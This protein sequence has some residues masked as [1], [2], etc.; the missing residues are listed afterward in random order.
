MRSLEPQR[1]RAVRLSL[2]LAS[3]A[4]AIIVAMI[5]SVSAG[6]ADGPTERV[7]LEPGDNF[8]GWVAEPIAVDE[9]FA[10]I[11]SAPLIYTWSADSREYRYAIRDVGGTLETIEPGTSVQ[12]R[13][14]GEDSVEWERPL[15]PAKGGITLY[16]GV[17]WVAWNGR[18]EWPLDQV[19]R[20]IG[21]SLVSIEAP[22]RGI[23]Y[24]PGEDST[25]AL[26][27]GDAL[28]VRVS[29]DLRWLQPTGMMPKIV[30][31]GDTSESLQDEITGD[32]RRI[33]D[34]LTETFAVESDFSET[35][36]LLF[37][38]ID[39]AVEHA[40]SG[41][42]P[43]FTGSPSWLR[44]M[45]EAG[46]LGQAQPWGFFMPSCGWQSSPP[47]ACDGGTTETLAHEWFHVL[48]DQLS[49]RHPHLSPTWMSEGTATWTQYQLPPDLGHTTYEGLPSWMIDVVAHRDEPLSAGEN[50][51]YDWVYWIGALVTE[52]LVEQHGID[53]LL[54]FDRQLYPQ[55]VGKDRR[56]VKG[57]GWH[58]TF[59]SVFR[60]TVPTFY[61]QIA[62]WRETL[63]EPDQER[64]ID[65]D[66][67]M[68]S[69]TVRHSDGSPAA[70]LI[71]NA[72][73]Y[74]EGIAIGRTRTA[75]IGETGTFSLF[76]P[77]D[78]IQRLKITDG[79]CELWLTN[80]GLATGSEGGNQHRD[81]D[82]RSLP[83]LRLTIPDG[84]CDA[85][86]IS[87]DVL[88]LRGDERQIDVFLNSEDG[89][90][91]VHVATDHLGAY[92]AY[93]PEAGRYRV[94]VWL[95]YCGLWYQRG[96]L[97][98]SEQRGE[99]IELSEVP[100]TISVRIPADLCAHQISGRLVTTGGSP[101]AG[102]A[103]F[104][105]SDGPSSWAPT[106]AE[107]AFNITVPNNGNYLLGFHLDDCWIRYGV[108]GA[109]H[110]WRSGTPISVADEDVTGIE[111]I[112][113][114]DPAS[115]CR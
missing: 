101:L 15:T 97:V 12:I 20:G 21:T 93:A 81:L 25:E 27:R 40:E 67:V 85:N 33:L 53:S 38:S 58:E 91:H 4:V 111:F 74:Q 50:G 32:I 71:A 9:L 16:S 87:I 42:E 77:S 112:V 8:I 30:F 95:D 61:S 39:A 46:L 76:L 107:G 52:Q 115:L 19:A 57:P 73:E 55:S 70:G 66:D 105:D 2:A 98:A 69:G 100:V 54:E 88:R 3:V 84:G 113:P 108:S 7:T 75:V 104:A 68:L 89:E 80:D 65:P 44:G 92:T 59:E 47:P 24:Q 35:T 41:Q 36:I 96:G 37:S 62:S 22:E 63:P 13:I 17:N 18:D 49:T 110:G 14:V 43:R 99:L 83:K 26:R 86:R 29:R 94:R 103:V 23:V 114:D 90:T 64:S 60:V 10:Q 6:A 45:L 34:F 82:T 48:Q 102:V 106:D 51:F 79:D 1:M 109:T 31:V 11:P 78:T 56:W 72:Q 5:Y 28:Q